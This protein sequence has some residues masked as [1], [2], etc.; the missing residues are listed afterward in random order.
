MSSLPPDGHVT[1]ATTD[2]ADA[3]KPGAEPDVEADVEPVTEL[4]TEADLDERDRHKRRQRKAPG[5]VRIPEPPDARAAVTP[6]H[7]ANTVDQPPE[8]P[9]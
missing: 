7:D 1:P 2:R 5:P 8:D 4:V 6:R 9:W 3:V